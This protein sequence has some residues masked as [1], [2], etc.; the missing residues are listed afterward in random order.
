M[1]GLIMNW[2]VKKLKLYSQLVRVYIGTT[3]SFYTV[4]ESSSIENM[5]YPKSQKFSMYLP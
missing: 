5:H 3:T 1:S 4:A 2:L